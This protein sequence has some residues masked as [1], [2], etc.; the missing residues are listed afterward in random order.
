MALASPEQPQKGSRI[1]RRR[2]AAKNSASLEYIARQ[3]R[4]LGAAAARF[5]KEGFDSADLADIAADA[6]IDRSNLYYYAEDKEDLYLQVLLA[7]KADVVHAAE[8]VA[9]SGAPASERLRVLMVDLMSELDRQ[10]PYLYLRYGQVIQSFAERYAD[11][12]QVREMLRLTE[13][14]FQAFRAVVR[15]GLRDGT[16]TSGLSPGIVAEA[17][18]GMVLQSNQ[19]FDP[20]KSRYSGAHLGNELANIML[21]GLSRATEQT[22]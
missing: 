21:N 12:A 16:L 22:R 17:A 1:A 20:K 13:R 4:V 19:W 6:G 3:Q 11:N 14:H 15:D 9:K 8:R 18:I 2:E 10:Y 5:Q 7:V